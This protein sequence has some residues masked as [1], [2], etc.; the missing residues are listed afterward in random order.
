MLVLLWCKPIDCACKY[1][2]ETVQNISYTKILMD[3]TTYPGQEL[4][5]FN[6]KNCY[7][8]LAKKYVPES[9]LPCRIGSFLVMREL[10]KILKTGLIFNSTVLVCSHN[11]LSWVRKHQY[12]RQN[13]SM[14]DASSVKER[15]HFWD[16][17]NFISHGNVKLGKSQHVSEIAHHVV[18]E[19][20]VSTIHIQ[21]HFSSKLSNQ[22]KEY[23]MN[24]FPTHNYIAMY[25]FKTPVE[26]CNSFHLA[27]SMNKPYYEKVF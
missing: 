11:I 10:T 22:T 20:L 17:Q 14:L 15:T 6:S 24:I 25:I 2:T 21:N 5:T 8:P 7:Y 13:S 12:W 4:S 18:T 3:L 19:F 1:T 26:I 23:P 9:F 16:Q 27:L